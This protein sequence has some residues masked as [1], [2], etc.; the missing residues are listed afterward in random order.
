VGLNTINLTLHT[1]IA[2][3]SFQNY[4]KIVFVFFYLYLFLN[5]I[6]IKLTATIKLKLLLKVALNTIN[7]LFLNLDVAGIIN[8]K[9]RR[10]V[11]YM[12]LL[13]KNDLKKRLV[14]CE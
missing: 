14:G 9:S 7:H 10:I 6:P 12:E 1:K 5:F 8:R 13:Y 2:L 4:K 3:L 11:N